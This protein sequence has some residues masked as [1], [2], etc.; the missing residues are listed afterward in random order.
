MC[1]VLMD[2]RGFFPWV[3][4]YG[5]GDEYGEKSPP[6]GIQVRSPGGVWG[7]AKPPEA[8]DRQ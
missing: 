7:G 1:S 8:D 3:G 5:Y 6:S 2:A 4:K